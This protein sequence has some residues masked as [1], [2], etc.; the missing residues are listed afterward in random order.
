M[1][2]LFNQTNITPG[3][4]QFIT[5]AEVSQFAST[6]TGDLSGVNISSL[7]T[8][9]NPLLS[10]LNINP[11]GYANLGAYGQA[12]SAYLIST[13]ALT[14]NRPYPTATNPNF[15]L[16]LRDD[17]GGTNYKPLAVGG[18]LSKNLFFYN[19]PSAYVNPTQIGFFNQNSNSVP[20]LNFNATTNNL[21]LTNI[22]SIN[23][24]P[25]TGA[26]SYTT[27]TG[28]NIINTGSIN[29]AQFV[30]LSSINGISYQQAY[31]T[32]YV[33]GGQV[34]LATGTA[35]TAITITLPA[36]YLKQNTSYVYD[37]PVK[38]T[39]YPPGSPAN[40]NLWWGI[41]LGG[42]GQI[43]YQF[44]QYI[45][46]PASGSGDQGIVVSI[47][48]VAQTN[49][50]SPPATQTIEVVCLQNGGSTFS[51][52][53]QNPTTTGGLNIYSIKPL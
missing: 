40:F 23:G 24:N 34:S 2:V 39:S 27:L 9:P 21:S 35:Q 5:R 8:N 41:R 32:G 25:P 7:L 43:N 30:G 48:G 16:G 17:T 52:T 44:P 36:G 11:S 47:T 50:S 13:S 14:Y 37:V 31:S 53:I 49:S 10:T 18:L 20:A 45:F 26:T 12:S 28:Q 19:E 1:S 3:T 46:T 29:N 4:S 38:F 42:N 33:G 15:I 6:I 51:P 22:S